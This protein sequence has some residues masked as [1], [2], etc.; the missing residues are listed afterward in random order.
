MA[1]CL[2]FP[3]RAWMILKLVTYPWLVSLVKLFYS[4]IL[5]FKRTMSPSSP[6]T[7]LQ[8]VGGQVKSIL[9]SGDRTPFVVAPNDAKSVTKSANVGVVANCAFI[10]TL[11]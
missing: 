8:V 10:A 2:Y 5:K 4:S 11:M 1:L 9:T 6:F 3:I 7:T